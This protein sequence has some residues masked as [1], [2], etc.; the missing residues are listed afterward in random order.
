MTAQVRV[1]RGYKPLELRIP[2]AEARYIAENCKPTTLAVYIA[3]YTYADNSTHD[4]YPSYEGIMKRANV[5]SKTTVNN[6]LKE[7]EGLGAITKQVRAGN[8]K[9]DPQTTIY[10]LNEFV[11]NMDKDEKGQSKICTTPSTESVRKLA[12]HELAPVEGDKSP[13]DVVT[14]RS[15]APP[16]SGASDDEKKRLNKTAYSIFVAWCRLVGIDSNTVANKSTEVKHATTLAKAGYV[17]EDVGAF[18]QW[19]HDLEWRKGA[20]TLAFMVS[21]ANA[22]RVHKAEQDNKPANYSPPYTPF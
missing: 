12:P 8:R 17:P 10:T 1:Q 21:Q 11:Q 6:A 9:K 14:E 13:S 3:L 15:S 16:S 5:G 22:Y 18:Y 7:L 20:V 4:C 19:C 2:M